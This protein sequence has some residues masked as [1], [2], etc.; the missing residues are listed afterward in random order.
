M[1]GVATLSGSMRARFDERFDFGDRHARGGRHHRIE[2]A[3]GLPVDQVALRIAL[4]RPDEREVGEQRLLEH[5]VTAVD[6]A[7]LL[8]LGDQRAVAGRREEAADAGAA[9]ADALGERAL[10]HQFDFELAGQELPLELLVLADV[11]GDH[12][13]HLPVL[14]QDADPEAVDAG[15]V[16]DDRELLRPAAAQGR[17]QVLGN[18]AQSEAAHHDRGAVR[19]QG[20]RLVC[21]GQDLLHKRSTR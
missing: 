18:A 14:E 17:D 3:R 21:C 9:G 20:D 6:L 11:G 12:L 15:V 10:R 8:A 16:A 13:A 2:V 1:P 19:N 4:P 7:R 5:V